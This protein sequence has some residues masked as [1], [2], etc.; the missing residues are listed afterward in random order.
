MEKRSIPEL[1]A[2]AGSMGSLKAAVNAGADAVYLSGKRFGARYYADNFSKDQILIALEYAH[3]RD[4]KVYV[5]VNTL[6]RDGELLKVAEYLLWLYEAGVDAVIL[7]DIGVASLCRKIIPDMDLHASTQMTINS[8]EGV[9]WA[10]ESG[11][12]RVVLSRE[13]SLPEI[14]E[15]FQEVDGKVELEIFAHGALCYSYSGQCLLSS[16]IGGRSGNQGRCAQPCRKSYQLLQG[17]IDEYGKITSAQ[18]IP[19]KEK[20]LLSTRDLALYPELEKII[21]TPL[22]S[23]KIEGR[24]RSPEYVAIVVSAYRKALNDLSSNNWTPDE[25]EISR[26]KL[27]FNRG[28]TSG[29]LLE[30]DDESVM[31]REAPGNRG[32]YLGKVEKR[33]SNR[34]KVRNNQLNLKKAKKK[35]LDLERSGKERLN[36]GK[37]GNKDKSGEK[38]LI[39][40]DH[41]LPDFP[42]DKGDGIAFLNPESGFKY[43]MAIEN[44]P[45]Y[46]NRDKVLLK[47]KKQI[48]A[49]SKVYQT[50][51][52]S[53]IREAKKLTEKEIGGTIVL[54]IKMELD[55]DNTPILM[56]KF[57]RKD[58]ASF[59]VYFKGDFN[60]EPAKK[61]PL[62]KEQIISQLK[63]TGGTPFLVKNVAVDYSGNLFAPISKLNNIRR[64][65]INKAEIQL[66]NSYKPSVISVKLA[67]KNLS[68]IRRKLKPC[69]TNPSVLTN[70]NSQK[71]PTEIAVYA[72]NIKTV[73][74]A[75]KGGSKRI[76]F[77]P[78]V[79]E[80]FKRQSPCKVG[81]WTSRSAKIYELLVEAQE[82][83]TAQNATMI[84]KWPSITG[85]ESIKNLKKLITPMYDAGLSEVMIGNMG[86]FRAIKKIN[87]PLKICGSAALNICN[88]QT[89]QELSKGFSRLTLSNELSKNNLN[90]LVSCENPIKTPFDLIVQGNLDSLISE[91]CLLK[92]TDNYRKITQLGDLEHP[93]YI[94]D[95]KKRIFPVAI[96]DEARTH[97]MN[98]VELCLINYIPFLSHMGFHELIIDARNKT[99]SYANAMVKYYNQSRDLKE[100]NDNNIRKLNNLKKMVKK[101]SNG[102]ITTGNFLK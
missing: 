60:L 10:C 35:R 43:G 27:A 52:N 17:S 82:L 44:Q 71:T 30:S 61:R 73:K 54:D 67:R 70:K 101:I 32:L 59:D 53:L 24:M 48:P 18:P 7:Q 74:R 1:L 14:E 57:S 80:H 64:E 91:N 26:L 13:L 31:G 95:G 37:I 69:L 79:W 15:I 76:Y 20:Y 78:F 72:S 46:L 97:I 40:L 2:P 75:L 68:K 83:C 8:A 94:E 86:A 3:L 85:N 42:L 21:R 5:T 66:L 100:N 11:F 49:G 23:L 93:L 98:S 4:V 56:G 50:R 65:F 9:K 87:Y 90:N 36:P 41:S 16:V 38:L 55:E 25:N 39:K 96:D 6:I 63:K 84:W 34:E 89:F 99:G 58:G 47:S 88:H 33:G 51:D 28:F 19:T 77:E 45:E 22:N 29:Y 81:K 102:G 92:G 12:K 62:S